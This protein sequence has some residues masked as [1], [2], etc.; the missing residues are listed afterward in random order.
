MKVEQNRAF[1]PVKIT[2]ET[3]EEFMSFFTD[4]GSLP[5]LSDTHEKLYHCLR[6]LM[7][8]NENE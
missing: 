7:K 4:I 5:R 3:K 1:V 2:L 6:N 8:E